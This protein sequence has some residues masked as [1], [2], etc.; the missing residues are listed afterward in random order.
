[1]SSLIALAFAWGCLTLLPRPWAAGVFAGALLGYMSYD[2]LHYAY[3]A[4]PPTHPLWRNSG[5]LRFMRAR[6]LRHHTHAGSER[7]FGVT[8]AWVDLLAGTASSA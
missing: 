3:H 1:M 2:A 5:W 6:H 7:D 4:L 8:H